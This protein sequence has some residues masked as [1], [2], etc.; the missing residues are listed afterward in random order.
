M[1]IRL[2]THLLFCEFHILLDSLT[3]YN[4]IKCVNIKIKLGAVSRN[5]ATVCTNFLIVNSNLNLALSDTR[6]ELQEG[7]DTKILLCH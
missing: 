7:P 5:G 3:K 6:A 2:T 1:K 4:L